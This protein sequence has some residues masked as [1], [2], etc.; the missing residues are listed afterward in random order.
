MYAVKETLFSKGAMDMR[1][2]VA[3]ISQLFILDTTRGTS[4][5]N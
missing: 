4:L 1:N 3:N 2:F 5:S